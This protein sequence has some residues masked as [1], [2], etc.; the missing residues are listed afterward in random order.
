VI[1]STGPPAARATIRAG[2]FA[3]RLLAAHVLLL[4]R[5]L[6]PHLLLP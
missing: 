2:G 5:L 3:L 1:A 4:A 6:L